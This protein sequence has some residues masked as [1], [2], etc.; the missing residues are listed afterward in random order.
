MQFL[1]NLSK[2]MHSNDILLIGFDM[3]KNK[4]ILKN[5]YNDSKNIT[6]KFNKNILNVINNYID[7]NFDLDSFEHIVFY[8]ETLS[9]IEMHLKAI[10]DIIISSPTL[11]ETIYIKKGETI[12]TENSYKFSQENIRTLASGSGLEIQKIFTDKH[13]WFSLVQLIK[14]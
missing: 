2:I 1:T 10:K 9:R 12:H 5:A 11:A 14:K 3:V 7:T 6:E 8:N 4:S 13:K